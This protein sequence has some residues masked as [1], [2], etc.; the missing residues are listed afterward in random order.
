MKKT[1]WAL[2]FVTALTLGLDGCR[3]YDKKYLSFPVNSVIY[4]YLYWD[5]ALAQDPEAGDLRYRD[6]N[7]RWAA[8]I[9]MTIYHTILP[10]GWLWTIPDLIMLPFTLAYDDDR[11]DDPSQRYLAETEDG[12]A[13]V[14]TLVD[15]EG[16][17]H[18]WWIAQTADDAVAEWDEFVDCHR[19][20][21]KHKDLQVGPIQAVEWN[22]RLKAGLNFANP[23]GEEER[24]PDDMFQGGFWDDTVR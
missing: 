14:A 2:L 15:G 6:V 21:M 17:L 12:R 22:P 24:D 7:A 20:H 23:M 4:D 11:L 5:H 1:T 13:V 8:T 19:H 18:G 3:A 16:F 10:I 9:E